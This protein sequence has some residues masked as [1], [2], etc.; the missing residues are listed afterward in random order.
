MRLTGT[1]RQKIKDAYKDGLTQEELSLL[2][3]IPQ[4]TISKVLK[5]NSRKEQVADRMERFLGGACVDDGCYENVIDGVYKK[6]PE[7]L[8]DR[9]DPLEVLEAEE[10]LELRPTLERVDTVDPE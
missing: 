9:N 1:V 3:D 4:G 8:I 2:F 10:E 6:M 7:A 5:G